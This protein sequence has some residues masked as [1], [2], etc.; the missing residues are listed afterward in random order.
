MNSTSLCFEEF[1]AE[2]LGLTPDECVAS[3]EWS[4]T[5]NTI[6]ALALRLGALDLNQ[7]DRILDVQEED[8]RLFGVLAI[9]LGFMTSSQVDRL[10]ELQR[11][12]QIVEIGEHLVVQGKISTEEMHQAITDYL[13]ELRRQ[14]EAD[15]TETLDTE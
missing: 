14:D 13:G 10:I 11:Y 2:R 12:H 15:V 4:G 1:L 6:G 5:G 8:K 3:S 7:I 9:D